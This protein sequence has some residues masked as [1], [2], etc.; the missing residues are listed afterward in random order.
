MLRRA[1]AY[2]IEAPVIGHWPAALGAHLM[3]H[4]G[5]AD[6]RSVLRWARMIGALPITA[7]E[8]IANVN[9]PEDLLAL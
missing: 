1:P 4:A 6:D 2:C 9:T 7:G 3:A 8:P 5:L